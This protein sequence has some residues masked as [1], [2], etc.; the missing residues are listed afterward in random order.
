M[1]HGLDCF[2]LPQM[3]VCCDWL[4]PVHVA[5]IPLLVFEPITVMVKEHSAGRR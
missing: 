4:S 3:Q 1:G 5:R 2:H